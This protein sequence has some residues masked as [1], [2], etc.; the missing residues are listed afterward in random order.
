MNL[1]A[2]TLFYNQITKDTRKQFLKAISDKDF[3]Q[4]LVASSESN[5]TQGND[6][7]KLNPDDLAAYEAFHA[8]QSNTT[9]KDA[10][11]G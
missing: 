8:T 5:K 3:M 7:N 2:I 9:E 10:I 6:D 1:N 4:K 11:V